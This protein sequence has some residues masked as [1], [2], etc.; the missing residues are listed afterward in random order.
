MIYELGIFSCRYQRLQLSQGAL[1]SFESFLIIMQHLVVL[2]ICRQ[3]KIG[4]SII[5]KIREFSYVQG[6]GQWKLPQILNCKFQCYTKSIYRLT[7]NCSSQCYSLATSI[8]KTL[9]RVINHKP[10][11]HKL[12]LYLPTKYR[13]NLCQHYMTLVS[14]SMNPVDYGCLD[15]SSECVGK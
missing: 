12:Q 3:Y 2:T 5:N 15:I 6:F 1:F 14:G 9:V 4:A 13:S 7:Q 8:V 11:P 10:L